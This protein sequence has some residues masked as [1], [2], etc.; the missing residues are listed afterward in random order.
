MYQPGVTEAIWHFAGYLHIADELARARIYYEEFQQGRNGEDVDFGHR[1]EQAKIELDA[2]SASGVSA[3]V[4]VPSSFREVNLWGSAPNIS[5]DEPRLD[6]QVPDF[7][8]AA[9]KFPPISQFGPFGPEPDYYLIRWEGGDQKWIEIHQNNYMLANNYVNVA[10]GS[11]V[12]FLNTTDA[13]TELGVLIEA[14]KQA[15]PDGALPDGYSGADVFEFVTAHQKALAESGEEPAQVAPGLYVDGV[16]QEPPAEGEEG[17]ELHVDLFDDDGNRLDGPPPMPRPDLEAENGGA[18]YQAAA[19]GGKVAVNQAVIVDSNEACGAM[20]VLGDWY[21]TNAIFQFNAYSDNDY[22]SVGGVGGIG[23]LVETGGNVA[24]NRAEFGKEYLL[25]D[26]VNFRGLTGYNWEIE[27][28]HGDFYDIKTL[29]QNNWVTSTDITVQN[30]SASHYNLTVDHSGQ[31]NLAHINDMG[32]NYD[33]IIVLGDYHSA[34]YIK[35]TN[36]ILDNDYAMSAS[37]SGE[38]GGQSIYTG[39][40]Y[41]LNMAGIYRYTTD[42]YQEVSDKLLD[43]LDEVESA[44]YIQPETWWQISGT[45]STTMNVLYVTGNYYDI[46]YICQNNVISDI[47]TALQLY[48]PAAGGG[49]Q[50]LSTGNNTAENFA[51]I[52]DVGVYGDQFL[53]GNVYEESV[54]IQTNIV[55]AESDTVTYGD[56]NTL[57]NEIV[58][59]VTGPDGDAKADDNGFVSGS[60]IA[61]GG[62]ELGSIMT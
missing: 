3:K 62:D 61:N 57:A 7:N 6:A 33:L 12:E 36:V 41:L 4:A 38:G 47:D 24:S 46:N 56:A 8:P 40:N 30:L 43:F 60:T 42:G 34:N 13:N 27:T 59:F 58:A 14:S 10:W 1:P 28:V 39:Q 49:E 9:N 18:N 22:V 23:A 37:F 51:A 50:Y 55:S 16:L 11:G 19:V 21:I 45:G 25:E 48:G 20:V 15:F 29:F 2:F 31:Y 52:Y 44:D 53:G 54:L 35:Q 5:L 26:A 17:P 32:T